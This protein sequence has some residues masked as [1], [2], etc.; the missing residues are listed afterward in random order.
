M[1]ELQIQKVLDT[2]KTSFIDIMK[3]IDLDKSDLV[4]QTEFTIR[5]PNIH[6][7]MPDYAEFIDSGRRKNRRQP[8]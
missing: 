5:G 8:F 3:K 1:D 7:L 6:L 4:R 2:L